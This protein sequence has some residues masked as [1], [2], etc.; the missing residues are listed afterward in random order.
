MSTIP[1][2]HEESRRKAIIYRMIMPG[3]I[4]PFGLKSKALL[5]RHNYE[6]EDHPL[7]NRKEVDAIKSRYG[8]KT[9][10]QIVIGDERIGGY[11]ELC[12]F[13]GTPLPARDE[14]TYRPVMALFAVAALMAL[15]ARWYA[16]DISFGGWL[17]WAVG[18]SMCLL[19]MQKLQDIE[20]FTTSFLNYDLLA[21]RW[22]GYAY[23]YPFAETI[24]GLLMITGVLLWVSI[25]VALFIG[26]VGAFSVYQAV[27]VEKRELK[28]A[29]VGGNSNVPLGSVSL[30]E[31]L[32]MVFMALWMLTWV[33]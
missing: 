21:R 15:A 5:E 28:C 9:T 25:P 22:V 16:G 27:Y 11:S 13:L 3:H 29:C 30:I 12:A 26:L 32:M 7:T 4:C 14:L 1:M 2:A 10:P 8:V 33:I 20:S 18:F 17:H 24:A 23:I 6:V 19:G 31:N